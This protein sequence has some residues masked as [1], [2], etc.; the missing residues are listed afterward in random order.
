MIK[1][2]EN[3]RQRAWGVEDRKVIAQNT[4]VRVVSSVYRKWT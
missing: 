4:L 1:T 2:H 3:I